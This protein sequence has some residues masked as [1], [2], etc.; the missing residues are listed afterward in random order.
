MVAQWVRSRRHENFVRCNVDTLHTSYPLT[1]AQ[2]CAHPDTMGLEK[3][4]QRR[5]PRPVVGIIFLFLAMITSI[6]A[7]SEI[8]EVRA[9]TVH[10]LRTSHVACAFIPC[11]PCTALTP[12]GQVHRKG[13]LGPPQKEQGVHAARSVAR[14]WVLLVCAQVCDPTPRAPC[15]PMRVRARLRP[16][17]VTPAWCSE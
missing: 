17:G 16:T 1:T 5:V 8:L 6:V 12:P 14:W 15:V 9:S 4:P 13:P 3:V 10:L 2:L 7:F 11:L